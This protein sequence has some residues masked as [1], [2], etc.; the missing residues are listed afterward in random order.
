MYT[1]VYIY[2]HIVRARA[3]SAC[4]SQLGGALNVHNNNIGINNNNNNNHNRNNNNNNSN[5]IQS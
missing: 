2:M 5:I 3:G 1:C 4:S